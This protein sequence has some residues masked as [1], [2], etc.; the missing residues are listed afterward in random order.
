MFS[1]IYKIS[2]HRGEWSILLMILALLAWSQPAYGRLRVTKK[3]STTTINKYSTFSK[4]GTTYSLYCNGY[5]TTI[6]AGA[7]GKTHVYVNDSGSKNYSTESA[8]EVD[9]SEFPE[10]D[11]SDVAIYGGKYGKNV[12]CSGVHIKMTGGQVGR[13]S[14]GGEGDST[15]V[16]TGTAFLYIYGGTVERINASSDKDLSVLKSTEYIYLQNMNYTGVLGINFSGNESKTRVCIAPSCRFFYDAAAPSTSDFDGMLG[17]VYPL[18]TDVYAR[19]SAATIPSDITIDCENFID[20]SNAL[21]ISGKLNIRS[22]GGWHSESG[23]KASD[24]ANVTIPQHRHMQYITEPATCTDSAQYVSRCSMCNT[25]LAPTISVKALG[26]TSMRNEEV[27]ATCY[28]SG[29]RGGSHCSRC[30]TS[31]LKGRVIPTL[32]HKYDTLYY[33]YKSKNKPACLSIASGSTSIKVRICRTCGYYEII[34]T[35]KGSCTHTTQA[36][37]LSETNGTV[38]PATCTKLGYVT[39]TCPHCQKTIGRQLTRKSH[40]M[41]VYQTEKAPTCTEAG[42]P[43]TYVCTLCDKYFLKRGTHI[44][45]NVNL[46]KLNI[47]ALGHQYQKNHEPTPHTHTLVSEATC[48]EPAWYKDRCSVCQA[49]SEEHL[50]PGDRTGG[51]AKGHAFCIKELTYASYANPEEGYVQLGCERCEETVNYLP[52][53]QCRTLGEVGPGQSGYWSKSKLIETKHLPTCV[54]GEGVYEM[55]INY[56]GRIMRGTYTSRIRPCGYLHNYNDNGV[57]KEKHYQMIYDSNTGRISKSGF[58]DINFVVQNASDG[59]NEYNY[60]ADNTTYSAKA[61]IA[62][63]VQI[64]VV[65]PTGLLNKKAPYYDPEDGSPMTYTDYDVTVYNSISD[66]NDAVAQQTSPFYAGTYGMYDLKDN[67]NAL[68]NPLLIAFDSHHGTLEY[69]LEDAEVYDFRSAV[70]LDELIYTRTF[71]NTNWQPLYVPFSVTVNEL[72]QKGLRVARLNDTHMYDDDFDGTIDRMT[73]EFI[74]VTAGTLQPNRPYMVMSE[75]A[76]NRLTLVLNDVQLAPALEGVVECSTVDQKISIVGTYQGLG[77]SVMYNNNYYAMNGQGALQRAETAKATL[78]PQRWYMKFENKDGSPISGSDFLS[79]EIRVL[80]NQDEEEVTSINTIEDKQS[81]SAEGE[82]VIYTLD[83]SRLSADK[84]L[85]Q[86]VYGEN[87]K[88]IIVR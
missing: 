67:C 69:E 18:G 75:K 24:Y 15:N 7:D 86:G 21:S 87:G 64:Q 72:T 43:L 53:F 60:V 30:G 63:P 33:T 13:I 74:R 44:I 2:K 49:E 29:T 62:V 38:N 85:R 84:P 81:Q 20:R 83:G 77:T 32:S 70:E 35:G 22:C 6:V 76:G 28:R 26:H 50:V 4:E 80:G 1:L 25:R 55:A 48:T 45:N 47:P 16:V 23:K 66:F 39:S 10:I 51:K 73:L 34:G 82:S 12:S 88:R 9:L 59:L 79:A 8:Y 52:F 41:K 56:G 37:S 42:H 36:A 61:Y 54:D 5:Y 31:L 19:G 27:E 58:G 46:N 78:K 65:G 14:I 57:C 17:A 40:S 71:A 3:V 11:W 68:T